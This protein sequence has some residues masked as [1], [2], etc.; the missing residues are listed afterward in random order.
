MI[1]TQIRYSTRSVARK[2]LQKLANLIH[3][4]A[5][6]HRH[7]DY[8]PPLDWVGEMPFLIIE[9]SN[10]VAAAL[11]CPP[12]PRQVAWVRLFAASARLQVDHAWE[13]LWDEVQQ[14]LVEMQAVQWAAAIPMH[15]W[16]E[17]ML[18]R[19]AFQLTHS[20]VMLSWECTDSTQKKA[21]NGLILRSMNLDDLN[22]VSKIDQAAFTPLWQNS[23]EYLELAFR[24]AAVA[25]VAE[26][27]NRM[28]GYQISTATPIGGHL[29]RLAV[30][31]NIQ[32][33]GIGYTLVQDLLN[34]FHRR[35]ARKV[36]V[37]TQ[38]DNLASLALYQKLGFQLTGEEYPVYQFPLR[39]RG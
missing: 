11:A 30:L 24:Q 19:S 10:T 15:N 36:T 5:Y 8:R 29:A 2:D 22:T 4:E 26:I 33:Q 39:E 32:G 27:E 25:T 20:I 17:T 38:K 16:F 1:A 13:T 3:F 14:R 21:P 28:V 34:Q 35:G 6:V 12:D 9:Q 23:L 31:P 37:N 7:L 18:R